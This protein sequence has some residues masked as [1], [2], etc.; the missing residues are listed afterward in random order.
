M[1]KPIKKQE[2]KQNAI[3]IQTQQNIQN[4]QELNN[5]R[6]IQ[7]YNQNDQLYNAKSDQRILTNQNIVNSSPQQINPKFPE[8]NE[9][10]YILTADPLADLNSCSSA[11]IKQES[12]LVEILTGFQMPNQYH[13][14]GKTDSGYIYLFK[15]LEKSTCLMRC[16]CDATLR[17]FNM[18]ILHVGSGN[19]NLFANIYKPFKCIC[20]NCCQR[21]K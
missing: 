12:E 21:L 11:L 10:Q 5:T 3:Q 18:D 9:I 4:Y 20:C 2:E 17:E 16:C 1:E 19:G 14:F 8:F 15:C 7:I 13:V 6:Y